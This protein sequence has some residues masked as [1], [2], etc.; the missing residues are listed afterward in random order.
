VDQSVKWSK[1]FEA[2]TYRIID[3]LMQSAT[4]LHPSLIVWPETA[5]PNFLMW[6]PN[7]LA[8]VSKMV[9]DSKTRALVG[10]LDAQK[11]QG[12]G[13][14]QFNSADA[15][16]ATGGFSGAFHKMHLVPFGE[17]MPFQKY[18]SFLGPVVSDLGNFNGGV[19]HRVFSAGEFT[20]TPL[21]CYEAIFPRDVRNA[22][23]TGAD[24]LVNISNDAWY[25]HTAALYQHALL[26]SAQAAAVRRPMARAANTGIS[27]LADASGRI[28]ASSTWWKEEVLVGEVFTASGETLYRR[29]GDWFPWL[30]VILP[31]LL[32]AANSLRSWR[33]RS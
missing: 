24:L 28:T 27:F 14:Q 29:W 9:R 1:A 31:L 19:S 5:S 6:N 23:L 18:L 8:R 11:V 33:A 12:L 20:Y 30:C 16:T 3:R 15:F 32:T 10:C 7:A 22:S 25:G 21:I 17:Y 2:G 26:C 13:I 4:P